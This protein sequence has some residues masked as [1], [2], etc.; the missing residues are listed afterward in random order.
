MLV[1]CQ[2]SNVDFALFLYMRMMNSILNQLIAMLYVHPMSAK[3]NGVFSSIVQRR[4]CWNDCTAA[5]GWVCFVRFMV[6]FGTECL[7]GSHFDGPRSTPN[8]Q[9]HPTCLYTVIRAAHRRALEGAGQG[10]IYYAQTTRR[11]PLPPTTRPIPVASWPIRVA[12]H[13]GLDLS[14]DW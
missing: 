4:G 7:G 6:W 2:S 1:R 12:K 13:Q 10:P 14:T 5:G 8:H 3:M 11:L 9:N